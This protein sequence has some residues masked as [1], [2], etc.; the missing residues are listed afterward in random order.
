MSAAQRALSERPL[1]V[2]RLPLLGHSYY[3]NTDEQ[4]IVSKSRLQAVKDYIEK[5]E[6]ELAEGR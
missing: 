5:L 2:D 4:R 1:D 3:A 6:A